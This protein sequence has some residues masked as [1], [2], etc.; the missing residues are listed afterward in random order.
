MHQI[1]RTEG[2]K[3]KREPPRKDAESKVLVLEE[4]GRIARRTAAIGH[5]VANRAD[6]GE[7]VSWESAVATA[8]ER[9]IEEPLALLRLAVVALTGAQRV[10]P[11]ITANQ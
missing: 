5:L 1:R 10:Y 3:A 11:A 9:K 7:V 6:R 8:E 2:R 4:V